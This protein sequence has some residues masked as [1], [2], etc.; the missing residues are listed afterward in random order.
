MEDVTSRLDLQA[1]R[2]EPVRRWVGVQMVGAACA[3]QEKPLPGLC[4]QWN[5]HTQISQ[6]DLLLPCLDLQGDR[7]GGV[8][9]TL[10]LT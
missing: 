10:R 5:T 7:Y 6:Q 1:K 2:S 4:P 3:K 9:G 8:S